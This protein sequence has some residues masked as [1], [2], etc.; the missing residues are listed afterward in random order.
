MTVCNE[1]DINTSKKSRWDR[2]EVAQKFVTIKSIL[3]KTGNQTEA[4]RASGVPRST[5]PYWLKREGKTGL[6]SAV[7]TFFASPEGTVFL[8]QLIHA[9][10]FSITQLA[11]GGVDILQTFLRL[12]QLNQLVASSHG[13]LY[14]QNVEMEKAINT[15]G[16][17]EDVRLAQRMPQKKIS[18]C[19]DETFHPEICLVAIEPISN[20]ILLEAYSEKRDAESWYKAMSPVL[21]NLPVEVIQSIS[22]EGKGLVKYVEKKLM[23]HHSSDIFHAQ[24]EIT[25]ATSAPLNAKIKQ[26]QKAHSENTMALA[27]LE[28]KIQE[29]TYQLSSPLKSELIFAQTIAQK[30]FETEATAQAVKKAIQRKDDVLSAKKG[31]SMVYHPYDL[32][33]GEPQTVEK[34]GEKIKEQLAVI[35]TVATEAKLSENSMKRLEKVERVFM[36]MLSTVTFFWGTVKNMILSLELSADLEALMQTILIPAL[37]LQIAAKKSKVSEERR[38]IAN[39][40]KSLL[41]RLEL[42]EVWC[43][44]SLELREQIKETALQCAQLF[45]RSSSCVEGRNGYLSLRHHSSHRLSNRKLGALTI[46]HNYFIKRPNET[47]AAERFY[48]SKPDDLFKYLL[49][50][51]DIPARSAKSRRTVQM[52]A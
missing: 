4:S 24:Q 7:E 35:K 9:A 52:A 32:N 31:L 36:F 19:Q 47:T 39:L 49:D 42:C 11:G 40:A 38:R 3:K 25:R 16:E 28:S 20:C 48:Q 21:N 5:L 50:H 43:F 33:S 45:Q 30:K 14:Q 15:F 2:L 8:H 26:T 23:A 6:S 17:N 44:L 13:A 37:Y 41:A 1:F 10:Q 34:I 29:A 22:D 18:V 51:L 46:I 27:R 12:S